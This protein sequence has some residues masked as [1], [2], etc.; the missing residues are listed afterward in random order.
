MGCTEGSQLSPA[1]SASLPP[2]SVFTCMKCTMA[3]AHCPGG[4]AAAKPCTGST[5]DDDGKPDSACVP[6]T[7]PAGEVVTAPGSAT[8]NQECEKPTTERDTGVGN[9]GDA[10]V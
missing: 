3:G 9:P 5:W 2:S 1:L 4:I 6:W 7:C 10:G 8:K